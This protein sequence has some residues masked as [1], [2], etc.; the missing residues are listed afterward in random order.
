MRVIVVSE[1][2]FQHKAQ[3]GLIQ[4][5]EVIQALSPKLTR[6]GVHQADHIMLNGLLGRDSFARPDLNRRYA[7]SIAEKNVTAESGLEGEKFR[8]MEL[9][10]ELGQVYRRYRSLPRATTA[11][12]NLIQ[13]RA[14]AEF[15]R[16][17][18][19]GQSR[20][21]GIA[22]TGQ[23]RAAGRGLGN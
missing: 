23:W 17:R 10:R 4:D 9:W 8:V 1:V 22:V 5:D 19:S 21:F 6:L 14:Q 12:N 13:K 15:G 11:F 18:G 20:S 7:E 2:G 3:T 16:R